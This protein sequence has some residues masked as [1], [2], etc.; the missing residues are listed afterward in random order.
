MARKR[1]GAFATIPPAGTLAAGV[2]VKLILRALAAAAGGCLSLAPVGAQTNPSTTVVVTGAR[3]AQSVSDSPLDIRVIDREQIER[4][5]VSGLAELLQRQAGVEISATGGA[6]Q[7]G[8]LF[9]RGSNTSHVL[10]LIDGVRVNSAT[11]GTNAFEHLSLDQIDRIEV[12]LGPASGLYGADAIGGVVQIFTVRADGLSARVGLGSERTRTAN[13]SLGGSRG[14]TRGSL[15][16]GWRESEPASSTNAT[17]VYSFNA[18]ADPYRNASLA[19]VLE[20]D[21]ATGQRV[22]VRLTRAD[23][24]THFDAGPDSDDFNRQR[25]TTL[26]FESRNRLAPGWTSLLRAARGTDDIETVGTYPGGFRTDQDQLTWQNDI[27]LAGGRVAAG[28]EWRRESVDSDTAFTVDTRRVAS[29]F[30]GWTGAVAP[31]HQLQLALRHDSNTQFGGRSTGNIGWGWAF[32]PGWRATAAAGSAFKAPSFND[33]YYPL[34]Y[35]YSGNPGLKPE[36]SRSLE[37]GL[38]YAASAVQFGAT[39]FQNRISDLIVVNDSFTTVENV[40]SARIRGVSLQA[41][42]MSGPWALRADTTLQSPE[43]ADTGRQLI[44]RAERF[45]SAGLDW[46]AGGLRLGAELAAT[47]QRYDDGANSAG[48]RLGG[49]ALVNLS[50]AWAVAPGWQ[51]AARLDNAADKGYTMVRGYDTPGR[52]VFLTLAWEK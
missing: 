24:R 22:T 25:L 35:G 30:G 34:Q 46:V 2:I 1:R 37:A 39:V 17:N 40:A 18:D 52:R 36:R 19:G 11:S 14:G 5:G 15:T 4:A 38:R 41:R 49:Y 44:R 42:W 9:L 31:G 21:W 6:G 43:N 12:L 8:G 16:V 13:A 29:A 48:A 32:A 23:S 28:L 7:P 20:H 45:G 26:A 33:L 47:G 27:D 3:M 51:L 10:L 50:A